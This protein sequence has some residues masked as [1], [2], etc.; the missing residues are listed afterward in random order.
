MEDFGISLANSSDPRCWFAMVIVIEIVH[1]CLTRCHSKMA[2]EGLSA[3]DWK[4]K[5]IVEGEA[6]RVEIV[7]GPEEFDPSTGM[8]DRTY[9]KEVVK[10]KYPGAYLG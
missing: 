1:L 2:V 5:S 9:S 6:Q 4:P 3:A 10:Y 8:I 7:K